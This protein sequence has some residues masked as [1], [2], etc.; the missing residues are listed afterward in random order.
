MKDT[1]ELTLGIGD[2]N[3]HVGKKMDE[4]E[5]VH[6]GNGIEEQNLEGSMLMEFCNQKDLFV[7]NT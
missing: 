1:K 7:M 4:F 2:F 3:R 6:G 5:G